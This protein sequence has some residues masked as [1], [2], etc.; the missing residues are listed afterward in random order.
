ME[1][2][3]QDKAFEIFGLH[4]IATIAHLADVDKR[5]ASR[6]ASGERP[7]PQEIM[8]KIEKTYEIWK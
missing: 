8:D 7:V 5:N 4:W 3:W 2:T 6:W 1:M